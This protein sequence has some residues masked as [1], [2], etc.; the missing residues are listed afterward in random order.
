MLTALLREDGKAYLF[1]EKDNQLSRRQ[2][3]TGIRNGDA[4][5]VLSGVNAGERIVVRD[6]AALSDAQTVKVVTE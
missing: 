1:V 3:E 5:V 2:V 6:V 4:I